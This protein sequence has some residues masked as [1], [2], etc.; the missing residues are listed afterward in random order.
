[1]ST[2]GKKSQP[3]DFWDIEEDIKH[4]SHWWKT[5]RTSVLNFAVKKLMVQI[6]YKTHQTAAKTAAK[7]QSM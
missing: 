5:Q 1:M 7:Y 3:T 4:L 6:T 2:W